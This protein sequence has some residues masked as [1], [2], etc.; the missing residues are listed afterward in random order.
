[1]VL[2]VIVGFLVSVLVRYFVFDIGGWSL[3]S[4]GMDERDNGGFPVSLF[5]YLYTN[6]IVVK[7]SSRPQILEK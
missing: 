2:L 1:M 5:L 4:S 3:G 6:H 7:S